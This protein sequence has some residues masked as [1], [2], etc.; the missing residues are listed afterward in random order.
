[1]IEMILIENQTGHPTI[2]CSGFILLLHFTN[3]IYNAI[4][5][6]TKK[7]YLQICANCDNYPLPS[8][9]DKLCSFVAYLAVS[10]LMN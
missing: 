3:T 10:S 5:Q 2:G 1:M 4:I 6:V 8:S 7:R 9:E